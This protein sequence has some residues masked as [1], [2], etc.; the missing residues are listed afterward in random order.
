[1]YLKNKSVANFAFARNLTA[2]L[3]LTVADTVISRTVTEK[4]VEQQFVGLS[5]HSLD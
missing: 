5:L 4:S 2:C 1:M 3:Y